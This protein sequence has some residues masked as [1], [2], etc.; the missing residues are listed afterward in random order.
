MTDAVS[1]LLLD[2]LREQA[3]RLDHLL[4][5][6]P[7]DRLDWRPASD[8]L[9]LGELIG[10]L[11]ECLAG[12]CAVLHGLYP[13]SLA[14]FS[15]LRKLTV[16]HRCPAPEARRRVAEYLE[17][18]EEGFLLIQ[19]GDLTRLSPTVFVKDGEPAFIL[20]LGNLEHLINHKHQLFTYLKLMGIPVATADLYH[21]RAPSEDHR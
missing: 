18:V 7:G 19:P 10:H 14:H 11:L 9:S 5:K 4:V 12:F 17:H 21:L 15:A 1:L 2:K 8:S 13:E 6:V 20:L 16:N 3:E